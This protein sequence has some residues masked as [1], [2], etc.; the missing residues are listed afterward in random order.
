MSAIPR[1]HSPYFLVRVSIK[2]EQESKSKVGSIYIPQTLT[3]MEWNTQQGEIVAIGEEAG[4]YFPEAKVGH[5]LL[6]HHFVQGM[7]PDDAREKHLVHFD[8]EFHYY[9]VTAYAF[10]GKDCE[11]YGV[12]DGEKIIPNKDYVFL[13]INKADPRNWSYNDLPHIDDEEVN[14][15]L[16]KTEHGILVF[17]EWKESREQKEA[18]QAEIKKETEE[19][20][21]SGN[22]KLK[23]KQA[24]LKK[25]WELEAISRDINKQAYEPH[26][27]AFANSELAE[28]FD[29][30]VS[31][32]DILGM[33]NMSVHT[34]IKFNEQE[35]IVAKTKF[36][37]FLYDK[38]VAA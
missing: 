15:A 36:I 4:K 27:I 35:F 24:I 8:E 22:H 37:G 6:M 14:K 20:S 25:E 16:Q 38:N 32:G 12:W 31:A 10:N 13:N 33:L 21:K 26:T 18:R 30:P 17:N 3:F 34:K 9:V 11:T 23:T 19:L 28:W 5:I 7:S 1:P 2:K 29:R